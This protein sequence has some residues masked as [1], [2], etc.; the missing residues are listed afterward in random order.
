MYVCGVSC[1][2]EGASDGCGHISNRRTRRTQ[3][4]LYTIILAPYNLNVFY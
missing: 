4:Q 1:E 2:R 3:Q